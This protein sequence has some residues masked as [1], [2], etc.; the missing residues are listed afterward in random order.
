MIEDISGKSMLALDVFSLSIKALKDHLLETLN[1]QITGVVIEDILWVLTVPAIWNENGKQFMR[2]SAMQA[3]IPSEKLLL[4]LEPEAASIYCQYLPTKQL[5]GADPEL[6][7]AAVGTKY[8]VVDIGGGTADITVH[9]KINDRRLKETCC[10]SGGNCGGTAVD[11]EF[12]NMMEKIMNKDTWNAFKRENLEEYLDL[13]RE[14]ETRK[15]AIRPDKTGPIHMVIPFTALDTICKEH[16]NHSLK[17]AIESSSFSS[18]L[19]LRKDK[20]RFELDTFINLFRSTI[21]SLVALISGVLSR[22]NGDGITQV[23]LVGGF[24]ECKLVQQAVKDAFPQHTVIVPEDS[25]LAVMKGAV[26]FGHQPN[27]IAQRI[28]QYTYGVSK[29]KPFD[30]D[31]HDVNHMEMIKGEAKCTHLFE[32]FVKRNDTIPPGKVVTTSAKSLPRDDGFFN[33]RI[34]QTEKENP[35]YTD[36]EGCSL[37]G[38]IKVKKTNPKITEKI[39]VKFVFGE[40]EIEGKI[41]ETEHGKA[42]NF[43]FDMI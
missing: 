32:A 36:E 16:L 6:V 31:K 8:M 4:A 22:K 9:E 38:S 19:S 14:F 10:A 42:C 7:V 30:P 21:D 13:A 15:R 28:S 37:L 20:M 12:F 25:D 17:S 34:F 1:K 40:T 2:T 5:F 27:I 33:L 39:K 3:G 24:S 11:Y 35:I 29:K 23:I 26:L 43:T 41:I 18:V